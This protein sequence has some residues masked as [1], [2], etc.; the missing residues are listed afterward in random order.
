MIVLN[1]G[2]AYNSDGFMDNESSEST[3]KDN[4]TGAGRGKSETVKMG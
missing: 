3:E 4:V 2:Q 1:Q